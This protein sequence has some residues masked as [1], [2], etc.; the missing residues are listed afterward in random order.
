MKSSITVVVL[1]FASTSLQNSL[2]RDTYTACQTGLPVCCKTSS[3]RKIDGCIELHR[4]PGSPSDFRSAC[5]DTSQIY[6]RCCQPPGDRNPIDKLLDA[7][8]L[9]SNQCAKPTGIDE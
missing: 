6:A 8:S 3:L 2:S 7:L 5:S 9:S 1:A 4:F